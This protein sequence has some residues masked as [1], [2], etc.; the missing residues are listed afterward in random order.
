M[1]ADG[2][3]LIVGFASRVESRTADE[4]EFWIGRNPDCFV[5]LADGPVSSLHAK[6]MPRVGAEGVE[7]GVE[8]HSRNGTWVDGGR[9]RLDHS[10]HWFD[11]NVEL[12]LYDRLHGPRIQLSIYADR[13]ETPSTVELSPLA[14]ALGAA[15]REVLAGLRA[16][17]SDK[18]IGKRLELNVDTVEKR[19]TRLRA[20]V[21]EFRPADGTSRVQLA[22]LAQELDIEPLR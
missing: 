22:A 19:L 6:V 9:V 16:G 12:R 2:G 1:S 11:K 14:K 10:V 7:W 18:A 13:T 15:E 3:R 21:R 5:W 4:G 8:D 17:W 20:K